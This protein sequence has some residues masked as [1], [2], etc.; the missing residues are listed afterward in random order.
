MC[1]SDQ[2]K[3]VPAEG[4]QASALSLRIPKVVLFCTRV[5]SLSADVRPKRPTDQQQLNLPVDDN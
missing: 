1:S 2:L 5:L 3:D 4:I